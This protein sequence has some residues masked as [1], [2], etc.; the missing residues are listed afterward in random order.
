M[1]IKKMEGSK[2][3]DPRM[4]LL[5]KLLRLGLK[6][7]EAW[8]IALDAGGSQVSV[9]RDYLYSIGVEEQALQDKILFLIKRF[10]IGDFG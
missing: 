3:S 10:K 6:E 1:R 5:D 2:Q 8:P 4:V 7:R 9:D